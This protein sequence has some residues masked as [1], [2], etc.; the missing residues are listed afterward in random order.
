MPPETL[1]RA[2]S[3]VLPFIIADTILGMASG[4]YSAAMKPT[5]VIRRR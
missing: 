1:P 4:P 2:S 5:A 3:N